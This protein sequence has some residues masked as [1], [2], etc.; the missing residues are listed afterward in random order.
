MS[1]KLSKLG[2]RRLC[3]EA[4]CVEGRSSATAIH[5]SSFKA[6]ECNSSWNVLIIVRFS[7]RIGGRMAAS[8]ASLSTHLLMLNDSRG[9]GLFLAPADLSHTDEHGGLLVLVSL[10][11]EWVWAGLNP[12]LRSGLYGACSLTW[13]G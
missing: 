8:A 4:S 11:Y 10:S 5:S 2:R 9:S 7:D 13:S 3:W 6:K 12:A 1:S